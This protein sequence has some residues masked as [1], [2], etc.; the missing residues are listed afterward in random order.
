[1]IQQS[2]FTGQIIHSYSDYILKLLN[3]RDTSQLLLFA[4]LSD[5]KGAPSHGPLGSGRQTTYTAPTVDQILC[6]PKGTENG[7]QMLLGAQPDKHSLACRAVRGRYC[8]CCR[9]LLL[10]LYTPFP[11]PFPTPALALF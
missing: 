8:C 5:S 10:S 2:H 7:Q 3:C 1:M 9:L 11:S 4:V 6:W